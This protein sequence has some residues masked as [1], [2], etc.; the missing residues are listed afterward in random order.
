MFAP[1]Q[2]TELVVPG[3]LDFEVANK[4]G[5]PRSYVGKGAGL[6]PKAVL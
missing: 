4:E 6:L 5:M 1:Q 2:K 3:N